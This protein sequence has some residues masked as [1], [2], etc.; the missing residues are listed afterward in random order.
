M[1]QK[2]LHC[3]SIVTNY[4]LDVYLAFDVLHI[5][6]TNSSAIEAS[7]EPLRPLW[8]VGHVWDFTVLFLIFVAEHVEHFLAFTHAATTF[9]VFIPIMDPINWYRI[10]YFTYTAFLPAH[11][12]TNNYK[13]IQNI[14]WNINQI[15]HEFFYI[16]FDLC[17]R[18]FSTQLF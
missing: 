16:L 8:F 18:I 7:I 15:I 6:A 12:I 4:S 17:R 13:N 9:P 1:L 14:R 11:I 10:I 2:W 3:A 5:F